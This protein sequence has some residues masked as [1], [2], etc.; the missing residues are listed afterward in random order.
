MT[1]MNGNNSFVDGDESGHDCGMATPAPDGRP[2]LL[3]ELTRNAPSADTHA[4]VGDSSFSELVGRL[5]REFPDAL[6]VPLCEEILDWLK[7][8]GLLTAGGR[9][10]RAH[11]PA[12]WQAAFTKILAYEFRHPAL[13]D[14]YAARYVWGEPLLDDQLGHLNP[15]EFAA[16]IGVSREA[17]NKAVL[18]AQKYFKLPPRRGQRDNNARKN[19]SMSRLNSLKEKAEKLTG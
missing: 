12:E 18:S 10:N 9:P 14:L 13:T 16:R 2:E 6:S 19:M 15:A 3:Q 5:R 4:L 17:V 7:D 8:E 11:T 1:G